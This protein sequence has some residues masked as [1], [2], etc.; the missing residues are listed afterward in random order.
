MLPLNE[1]DMDRG[2]RIFA[3]FALILTGVLVGETAGWI[4]AGIGLIPLLSGTLGWCP[5]YS[6]F[7]MNTCHKA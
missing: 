1:G 7:H 4:I 2:I 6:L 3:G 5:I